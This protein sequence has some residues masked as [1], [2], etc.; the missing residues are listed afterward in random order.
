[1]DGQAS[2]REQSIPFKFDLGD[3]PQDLSVH[4]SHLSGNHGSGGV[5]NSGN[6]NGVNSHAA[7]SPLPV[8][9]HAQSPFAALHHRSGSQSNKNNPWPKDEIQVHI[10]IALNTI[11][12]C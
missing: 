9:A 4:R 6:G 2:T 3:L 5:T 10:H 8:Q 12:N 1:M 7:L 11:T